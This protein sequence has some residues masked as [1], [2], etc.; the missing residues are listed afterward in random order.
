MKSN[1]A[2]K[3]II[4][5]ILFS[6][7]I[8]LIITVIQLY[9]EF[10]YDVKGIYQRFEQIE[11]SYE[12]SLTLAAW[13]SDREQLQI[14][15]D[16]ITELPD[17]VYAR[18][19]VEN[20]KDIASGVVEQPESIEFRMDLNYLYNDRDVYLGELKVV[21]SLSGV[22]KKM[23]NR[24]WIILLS[25]ALKTLLVA[26]F[27]YYIFSRLVT[28]HLIR[29]SKFSEN[30]GDLSVNRTLSLDRVQGA[31][32]E[33]DTVVEN[34]NNM[35]ARLREQISQ[36]SHQKKHLS[37]TLN[38]IGDA[39]ITTDSEGR[40]TRMNPVAEKLTGWKH[41]EAFNQLS[42]A[43][44]P[45]VDALTREPVANP[46][47]KVLSTG[48]TVYLSNHTTLISK[49]TREHQI[50]D[51]AAPIKDGDEIIGVVLVFNDITE[52]YRMREKL[53]SKEREQ[54]EI[55]QSMVDAVISIDGNGVISSFNHSAE[56]LFGYFM[57]EVLGKNIKCLMPEPYASL[58]DGYIKQYILTGEA[59]IIGKGRDVTGLR[60]NKE[61]FP[62]QLLIA[63][64]PR[65]IDG[66]QRFIGSCIDL[67]ELRQH[68]AQLRISQKMDALGKLTGGI[69]HD[70]NNMLGVVLGYAGLLKD[71]LAEQPKLLDY[72]KNIA[73]AGERGAKLTKKLLSFSREKSSSVDILNINML[74]EEQFHM[75]EKILTARI[76]LKFKLENNLW[77]VCLDESELEDAILNLCINAMHA[78]EGNGRLMIETSN[79]KI[80][81]TDADLLKLVAGD[82]VRLRIVDT[83]C[84]MDEAVR[85]KIF[86]PFFT[87]KG[88]KG[89]GLGLSQIYGFMNR[90]D[91]VVE[92]NSILQQGSTFSLYFP[93]F[94]GKSPYIKHP[95]ISGSVDLSGQG[96]VLVVDDEPALLDLAR[97]IL[98]QKN[99]QVLCAGCAKQALEIMGKER[100]DVLLSDIIMPDM[101]GYA[102]ASIVKEKHPDIKIQLVSGFSGEESIDPKN[103]P[104]SQTLLYKPYNAEVLLTGIRKL[105]Q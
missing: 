5:T 79:R 1:I 97:E 53:Q 60:K 43:V 68:E 2:R 44:F 8:T 52:Q 65:D 63:E 57:D 20:Y 101:D 56:I 13:V 96:T 14:I 23:I 98:E 82:Y 94:Q 59:K 10:Q 40:I 37:Q 18:V 74:L 27:V 83:G 103:E 11:N 64:L 91:G 48:K 93:R 89:T 92:V 86:D 4:Y 73:H 42:K 100:V 81:A 32:D 46:V 33:L 24:L 75:L 72:V 70:Y 31:K 85:E 66:A 84:G 50:A 49:N 36:I 54:R 15:L 35:H 51:S 104:L 47:D 71:A 102:L 22:Y 28:R 61:T 16:G 38:S 67:T 25:N 62:M 21:A 29:I 26:L 87:T 45:I 55:L 3:L 34:T 95:E 30:Y 58:H 77:L 80:T 6:S 78:I 17:I 41:K 105:L 7:V 99:Y 90:C 76:K 12:E 19:N 69:A 88:D 39:V 9:T